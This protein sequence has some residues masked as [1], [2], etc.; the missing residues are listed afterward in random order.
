MVGKKNNR[1]LSVCTLIISLF[2]IFL[3]A[4]APVLGGEEPYL[5]IMEIITGDQTD[6]LKPGRYLVDADA[7]TRWGFRAGATQGWAE[8][9]LAEPALI[10]GI[11]LDGELAA[12]TTLFLEYNREGRWIPF[13]ASALNTLPP[14]GLIDLSLDRAVTSQLR[15][16]LEGT[17]VAGSG[18]SGLAV[19]GRKANTILHKIK[20]VVLGSSANTSPDYTVDYLV[21]E[22][23][24]TRWLTEPGT[25][26]GEVLFKLDGPYLLS[27]IN[28]YFTDAANGE[29]SIEAQTADGWQRLGKLPPQPEGWCR[30]DL[31]GAEITTAEVRLTVTGYGELGGLGEVEIW[32]YGAYQGAVYE[33]M[34]AQRPRVVAAPLTLKFE[35]RPQNP[36]NLPG[37]APGSVQ[38]LY[39]CVNPAEKSNSIQHTIRIVNT[40]RTVLD[41]ADLKARYWFTDETGR[42]EQINV[43]W[44]S[45]GRENLTTGI[46]KCPQEHPEADSY[47]EIGFTAGAGKL[48][49]GA[50]AEVQIGMNTEKWDQYNQKNDY[51]FSPLTDEFLENPKYTAYLRGELAFGL[52]PGSGEES[53]GQAGLPGAALPVYPTPRGQAYGSLKVLYKNN[54]P[55]ETANSVQH[56]VKLVNVGE[57]PIDLSKVKLRYWFTKEPAAR[58]EAHIYWAS[59]GTSKVTTRFVPHP[60][61]EKE[62][63]YYLE[64]GFTGGTLAPGAEAEIKLGF[65]TE[66]WADYY[67]ANDY[68]YQPEATAYVEHLHYT[69]YLEEKLVW[70]IEPANAPGV[71]CAHEL[72][73]A[74]ADSE[75][76]P[77][78]LAVNGRPLTVEPL[79]RLRGHTLYKLPLPAE[80]LYGG[81]NYLQIMPGAPTRTLANVLVTAERKDGFRA[82]DGGEL[83]DGLCLTKA[84]SSPEEIS[85]PEKV[86]LE[87]VTVFTAAQA[88][89]ELYAWVDEQWTRLYPVEAHANRVVFREH[90]V[91]DRLYLETPDRPYEVTVSGSV[92]TDRAPLVKITWPAEGEA[93]DLSG[94]EEK[95]VTGLVD[96][97]RARVYV[98][99]EPAIQH[100]H[101]FKL[102]LNKL[103]LKPWEQAELIAVAR[104]EQG[105]EGSHAITV[106]LGRINDCSIDQPDILAYTK[107]DTFI[108]SGTVQTPRYQVKV[109]SMEA[110]VQN[111]RYRSQVPLHPGFNLIKIEFID[112][113]RGTVNTHYRRVVRIDGQI[114]LHIESPRPDTYTKRGAITVSGIVEGWGAV[115]V[116]VNGQAAVVQNYG[117]VS[118][119][120][121]L[122][123]GKNHLVIKAEDEYG[124]SVTQTVNVYA[125]RTAPVLSGVIPANDS[126]LTSSEI[127][128]TGRV[129]DHSPVFVYVNGKASLRE[130]GAFRNRVTLADGVY[131]LEISAEDLAGNTAVYYINI[132]VDTIPPEPFEVV[133][134]PA[135]WTNNNRPVL[136]FGTVDETSGLSHYELSINESE[137]VQITSP[138]RLDPQPDGEH[139]VTVRAVDKAGW[140]TT[141][142]TKIYIDTTPPDAAPNFR[143]VP[144][145]EKMILRWEKPSPDI[146]RYVVEKMRAGGE[147]V[148]EFVVEG[149]QV[150][151]I[152]PGLSTGTVYQYRLKAIDRADNQG[153]FT[154][155]KEGITGLAYAPYEPGRGAVVEYDGVVLVLPYEGLPE[156]IA[157]IQVTEVSSEHL[158]EKAIYPQVT[159]IYEFSAFR[160][161]EEE[162][163]E[164]VSFDHGYL[165]CIEYDE[166]NL[167]EGFPE[168]NLGVY[169]YDP[170]FDRWFLIEGSGVDI[171]NNRIYFLTNHFSSFTVQ[172]T[173]IQDL[174][175]Q[176]YKEAGYSPLKSYTQHGGITVSPQGGTAS[177]SVTELVLPGKNGFDLVI[178]RHYDTATARNDAFAMA[179]GGKIGINLVNPDQSLKSLSKVEE[180]ISAWERLGD[181]A[182]GQFFDNIINILEQYLF[183]QGDFAYSMGQGWRLNIPYVKAANSTLLLCTPE[184][185]MHAINEMEIVHAGGIP[186]HRRMTFKQSE[187]DDF[188]LSIE[189]VNAGV[190]LTYLVRIL[191]ESAIEGAKVRTLY[192]SRW[193]STGYLLRMKDGTEYE[194]DYLGRTTK[195]TDP[196]GLNTIRFYYD[197]RCLDYIEDSMGRK[198]RFAYEYYSLIPR[199][200]R[201]WV[202]DDPYNRR[203]TYDLDSP[204]LLKGATDV[205]GRLSEYDYDLKLLL[206]GTAGC[207]ISI[208]DIIGK[209][210]L[211]LAGVGWLGGFLGDDIELYGNFQAQI[212]Y[213]LEEMSAP[214]QG[215]TRV[216]YD[217]ETIMYG[218]ITTKYLRFFGI[219]IPKSITFSG[220]MEQRLLTSLVRV[221]IDKGGSLIKSVSYSCDIGYYDYGQPFISQTIEN[222]GKRK[223]V[224]RYQAME[225]D[226]YCWEDQYVPLDLSSGTWGS[227]FFRVYFP[228]RFWR[229]DVLPVNY[230]TEIR[231][232]NSNALLETHKTSYDLRT[233]RPLVQEIWHGGNCHKVTY[234][235]DNWGNVTYIHDYD[236]AHGRIT[237]SET[238]M[239]YLNTDSKPSTAVQWPASPYTLP[240]PA[241]ERYN[242]LLGKA[243]KNYAPSGFETLADLYLYS[244]NQYNEL[245][246]LTGTARWLGEEW[247]FTEM[248]YHPDHG[249]LTKI[250]NPEGHVTVYQYDAHGLPS[251]II[252]QQVVDAQGRKEDLETRMGYDYRTGW[253]MWEKNPRGYVTSYEYDRLGR[254]TKITAPDDDD[255][256]SWLPGD[257]VPDFR[258]NNPVTVIEYNDTDLYSVVT[259]PL[260]NRTKYDFDQLGRMVELIKYKRD[261]GG[262]IPAAVTKIQ[263]DAWDNIISIIDPNGNASGPAWKYT[264]RYEYDAL[265]RNTAIIHPD[266]TSSDAD[267]PRKRMV[268]DYNANT[269]TIWDENDN[270]TVEYHDMQG[271][272]IKR[273]QT[274]ISQVISTEVYYDGLG[275]QVVTI[276]P[277][278]SRILNLYDSANLLV[279][280]VLPTETFWENGQEVEVT[281]YRR[282]VYNKAGQKVKEFFSLP[283][284]KEHAIS[285]E[286]DN[287][288]R[289]IRTTTSY[290]DQ[291]V[292]KE[293]VTEVYY[294]Q[295]GNQIRVVDA[296]NTSLSQDEQKAFTYTYNAVDLLLTET[297]PAGNTVSYTY[298]AVGNCLSMTDPRGNSKKYS[299]DFT[300]IY[301]YDDL[302]RLVAGYLPKAPGMEKKPVVRLAYDARGNL[303]ERE[304]PDG[305]RTTYTYYPRNLVKTE[306]RQGHG[307]TYTIQRFY[308]AAGN[309]VRIRDAR[310]YDTTKEYDALHR[311]VK[312][313]YPEGN[314][315]QF[316]YDENSNQSGYING[317]F[318]RTAYTY[319]RHNQLVEVA[320]Q[321]YGVTAIYGYDRLG[322]M[323]MMKNGLGHVTKYDYDELGRLLL[324]EDPQGNKKT[325]RY[326]AVG[327]RIYSKDPNGTESVYEYYPNN[328]VK[329]ITLTNGEATKVLAYEYDEAGVRTKVQDDGVVTEYNTYDT[330]YLPDPFGRIHKETRRFEGK[331]Y[332]VEYQYDLMGRRTG[333]RYPTGR[334]VN[335][336][337]NQVGELTKVPGYIDTAPEYDQ[338]GLLVGLTA[339][340]GVKNTCAYDENTRLA[341]LNYQ[342]QTGI[343]KEYTFTYDGAN[344]I[345]TKNNDIFGYDSMNQLI[346]AQLQGYFEVDAREEK[347]QVGLARED[348]FGQEPLAAVVDETEIIEL[349]YAAGSIGVDLL[350]VFPVTRVELTPQAPV[351]RVQAESLRLYGS[352]DGSGY[353]EISGWTMRKKEN[354]LLEI[355]LD[356]PT[357]A[358]FL[359]VHSLYD[360]RDEDF[361]P[362]NKSEF[363]NLPQEL[364]RVYYQVKT[365]IEEYAYD[366]AGNRRT[367]TVT[368]RSPVTKEYTY[369]PNS[370]RLQTIKGRL[371]FEYDANGNLIKKGSCYRVVGDEVIFD[372]AGGDYWEYEYDLL[373]RLTKV[374]K[375]G[376][377]VAEYLY[378]EAG[379]RLKKTGKGS[380]IYYVFSTDGQ[381]LYEE[382][383]GE[384]TEYVYVLGKHFARVDGDLSAGKRAT[385]FYHT[386]HLG[387]TV[388]VTDEAGNTVW[389]SEYTPFGQI[390]ME[391]GTLAKAAKFTGKDLDEDTGLYYFNARWY[392]SELGR[393]I[394]E[395]PIKDGLN[396]YTYAVN[397]P[398]RF[399]DPTGLAYKEVDT[400]TGDLFA[401]I[402]KGDTLWKVS[403]EHYGS[404]VY[405]L[406]LATDNEIRD[407]KKMQIGQRIKLPDYNEL[408]EQNH[409]KLL[410]QE[411]I[412]GVINKDTLDRLGKTTGLNLELDSNEQR[413]YE[414]LWLSWFEEAQENED[415][416]RLAK[417]LEQRFSGFKYDPTKITPLVTQFHASQNKPLSAKVGVSGNIWYYGISASYDTTYNT[418]DASKS[419][420]PTAL[421]GFSID[422]SLGKGTVETSI[423]LSKYLSIGALWDVNDTK[424]GL[425][426]SGISG[427]IGPGIS[428]P[429][430]VSVEIPE[431][432]VPFPGL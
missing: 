381:I 399:V 352:M 264:T 61:R 387:S 317:N 47:L 109:N 40:G 68:T 344:N 294:D 176:E 81:E 276:D 77:V 93:I 365:R 233:M 400:E 65:N 106:I 23:T 306:T 49:P 307:K 284:N 14:E 185:T 397:N 82:I 269:L 293:A 257:G 124:N 417:L 94:W 373:N 187:G 272:I 25:N 86:F 36:G 138:Y 303:V 4:A 206:G 88:T 389:S 372:P 2:T 348:Y 356:M 62:A 360:E 278:G 1:T 300:I 312:I 320:D 289:V 128:V 163:L 358:R 18:L 217:Q 308:D 330:G 179:I 277:K 28:L 256:I 75:Q 110:P 191:G 379:Y 80:Y 346:Y 16:R 341:G 188:T 78:T 112:I 404:G 412:L 155:W 332:T 268:F 97:P 274:N 76:V 196:S 29:I 271:R 10:D 375:N 282:F 391:E 53:T 414:A 236:S 430:N 87:E 297:D 21:D 216:N 270:Q 304:E 432:C 143:V 292:R 172:A 17:G 419:F 41:L 161:G 267:N 19:L 133:A 246:Q 261:H 173:I 55:Q 194:M 238:W 351:N 63:D 20:P 396:W 406:Q 355:V 113:E 239:Y 130:D 118:A 421:V 84:S 184:G 368:L 149:D 325:F 152:D 394:S 265:G 141:A 310:G 119:P 319:N 208:M 102:P 166:A 260:Q 354:G 382:E 335:Y 314:I 316:E 190:D 34:G 331:T 210:I 251:A 326:D 158:A 295:N 125:D 79:L 336:Q 423:G 218:K 8:V 222:D 262:Y 425:Y 129:T 30:L 108:I 403:E 296:N 70:G 9:T 193:Y 343:L 401:I 415:T 32:G 24:Y 6:P 64:L 100:G 98:N 12:D 27:N 89:I 413:I 45:V 105:R 315:E 230:H 364:I 353:L 424:D 37:L 411:F 38:V 134:D 224:Y 182:S 169:Y 57:K 140:V 117:F 392:D 357:E 338:G 288:S 120:L 83:T 305:G 22:N 207:K 231:D 189:Q 116:M 58:Q 242:L 85:F 324:E 201:I 241:P 226:R 273:V 205:G 286:L 390:T 407:P 369:Y 427:H 228:L 91:T 311:L 96:N 60:Y 159:P 229:I 340:N 160:E 255:Q 198:V 416:E 418:F 66:N 200:K 291:G 329:K 51:S 285:Y 245:G 48:I 309:E 388:L 142:T 132:M 219:K 71:A 144:G 334:W 313:V 237:Q 104:D 13:I 73:L 287:L 43:Y 90:L 232:A 197:G 123:E 420:I 347:Q 280:T 131:R 145:Q 137:F 253:K 122:D 214:G 52:E 171:E 252:E 202:E 209:L 164:S 192:K 225:R 56:D 148:T 180:T 279:K 333:I 431:D 72:L 157:E 183:N 366:V 150:E 371:A 345:K 7:G 380:E 385:Y 318:Y 215:Y 59:M 101:T 221:Y 121:S 328:L 428:L 359:K 410:K 213:A 235:Y 3:A 243:V 95:E 114:F 147:K 422:F 384:Y 153:P 323:T 26:R 240:D 146:V 349:D 42:P 298:D 103:G 54:T 111:G 259:D 69:A 168:H 203:I 383:A 15:L 127:E 199:I 244:Y 162:P 362:V 139:S 402:E 115:R 220:N 39:K 74:F 254:T 378:D 31:A 377:T 363:Y 301:E 50:Y 250:V 175:P 370:N 170:M 290:T 281:P 227:E 181:W 156:G 339:A 223:T 398:L 212:M 321:V 247:A 177:T 342:N 5:E 337:Y 92:L 67:Q 327:N 204:G 186:G 426:F 361:N 263:Y 374:I 135:G 178:S 195:M 429:V 386:D 11:E 367:E 151:Y 107:E 393:F 302:Y 283:G 322:N 211:N 234:K 174:S 44:T 248:E 33:P 258:Q 409:A 299:G 154:Q 167:P 165:A 376:E 35:A 99:G 266:E 275:N 46:V 350:S 395:D 408:S 136:T 405:S 126:L 249:S